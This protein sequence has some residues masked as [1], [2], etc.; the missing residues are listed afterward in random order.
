MR[1]A[2]SEAPINQTR[3]RPF[4]R[5]EV[6]LAPCKAGANYRAGLA[7]S[8]YPCTHKGRLTNDPDLE[9]AGIGEKIAGKIQTK[10]GQVQKVIEKP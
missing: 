8:G 6:N 2:Q 3:C 5:C 7:K 9:G 10:I 1:F 4:S